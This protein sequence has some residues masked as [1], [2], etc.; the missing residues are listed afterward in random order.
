MASP[1]T[2]Y[3]GTPRYAAVELADAPTAR[4]QPGPVWPG[5]KRALCAAYNI[6]IA[7]LARWLKPFH[8]Q[9][10]E[11]GYVITQKQLTRRQ[12]RIIFTHLDPPE[13]Y[14]LT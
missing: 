14:T 9:L 12:V 3:E 7:T 6:S 13:G 8:P 4:P 11:A 1:T 10:K 5:S 2:R